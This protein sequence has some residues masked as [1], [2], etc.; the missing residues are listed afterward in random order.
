MKKLK[1]LTVLIFG[2]GMLFCLLGGLMLLTLERALHTWEQLQLAGSEGAQ[3]L[4]VA[5]LR[6]GIITHS[7]WYLF[8]GLLSMISGVGLF[9]L[10]EWARILWLGLLVLFAVCNF[11][12]FIGDAYQGR[13]LEPSNL[14]GYPVSFALIIAMWF[15]FTRQKTRSRFSAPAG[16]SP[17]T[18]NTELNPDFKSACIRG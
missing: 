12:W 15:Y 16:G 1:A 17:A 13:M 7:V 18:D 2:V 4:T 3:I 9:L 6:T 5:E 11:Y 14:I 8:L 10:K